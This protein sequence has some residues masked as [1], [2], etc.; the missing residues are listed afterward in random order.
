MDLVKS[1]RWVEV[2]PLITVKLESL[3]FASVLDALH[4]LGKPFRFFIVAPKD[5]G[6]GDDERALVRFFFEFFDEQTRAQMSMSYEL[7]LTWKL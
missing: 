4:N 3:N 5:G 6:C 7:C 2:R 1:E